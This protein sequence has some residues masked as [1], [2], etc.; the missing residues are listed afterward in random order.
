MDVS[1]FDVVTEWLKQNN[2]WLGTAVFLVSMVE[3]LVAVGLLVPGVAMLFALGAIAGTGALDVYVML[4][5]AF[6]GAVVGDGISFWLGFQYHE[7][8]RGWWPFNRHPSWLERGELFFQKY[9]VFSIVIGRFVGPVRPIIPVVAGMMDMPPVKFYT[10]NIISALGWAPV[11]LLPG[12]FTGA[13]L[14]MGDQ[15]PVQLFYVLAV[16][17][18]LSVLLPGLFWWSSPRIEMLLLFNAVICLSIY[19]LLSIFYCIG[20]EDF[21]NN[22]FFNWLLPLRQEW[23]VNVMGKVTLLGDLTVLL[24]LLLVMAGWACYRKNLKVMKPLLWSVPMMEVSLWFS[25]WLIQNPRPNDIDGLDPYSF[26]S[27]HTTQATFF[28][29]WIA[30]QLG[31]R[32]SDK[33]K[34]AIQSAALMLALLVAFSRLILNVHWIGDVL[35]GFCLGLFWVSIAWVLR[36]QWPENT[37]FSRFT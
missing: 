18:A 27:G 29:I 36:P 7:R 30:L 33:Q 22:Q 32:L 37:Y 11:Y 15:F 26:P 28:I 8:L 34:W 5:W 23:L 2:D 4:G 6:L 14:S 1:Y 3:S 24:V 25:K 35:G 13:A 12:F 31:E 21:I 16:I 17:I 10:V 20:A 19:F 9:G